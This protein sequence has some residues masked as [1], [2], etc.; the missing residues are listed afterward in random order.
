MNTYFSSRAVSHVVMCLHHR[1]PVKLQKPR[2]RPKLLYS[3]ALRVCYHNSL[4]EEPNVSYKS[5]LIVYSNSSGFIQTFLFDDFS[6]SDDFS[7]TPKKSMC[8]HNSYCFH[9]VSRLASMCDN[10]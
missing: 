4:L 6:M 2:L 3:M 10:L 8:S 1:S 5:L 7:V 9:K